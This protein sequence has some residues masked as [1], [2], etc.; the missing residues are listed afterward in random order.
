V[1]EEIDG[2]DSIEIVCNSDLDP[3]DIRPV[4]QTSGITPA[5]RSTPAGGITTIT[6]IPEPGVLAMLFLATSAGLARWRA[7]RL[8]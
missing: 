4:G 1:D 3:R 8:A 5:T 7:K 6:A 2:I